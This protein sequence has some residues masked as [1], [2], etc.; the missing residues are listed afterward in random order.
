MDNIQSC[1]EDIFRNNIPGDF[2]ET[3]V[4]HGGACIFMRALQKTFNEN[5]RQVWVCDSFEGLPVPSKAEDSGFN[6]SK[7]KFPEFSVSL[8]D[9]QRNFTQYE[10]LD[11][12]VKFLKGWF[13]DTLP[14][15]PIKKIALLRLDGDLYESTMDA[16]NALYDKV[17][18][19]GYIL[20]DDYGAFP[21]CKKAI[22]EFREAHNITA[23]LIEVDWTGAYWQKK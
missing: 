16:L 9:V 6:F 3:G 8:E 13:K 12:Q 21:P 7:G 1:A 11:D 19:G 14:T 20:I 10:M 18:S 23:P 17:E 4:W 15:A 2:V 22:D 5:S